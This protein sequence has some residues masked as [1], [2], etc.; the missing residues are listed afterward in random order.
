MP[1]I[2][3]L[4]TDKFLADGLFQIGRERLA[5]HHG[6]NFRADSGEGADIVHVQSG[7]LGRDLAGQT[8]KGQELAEGMGRGGK[9]GRHAHALG[10]LRNHLAERGVLA[11]DRLDVGHA[12]FSN[13]TTNAVAS[14]S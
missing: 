11:A 7:Q 2:A 1:G 13:G 10:Q 9:A 4:Q 14:K 6:T 12:Q 8:F 3:A 5:F